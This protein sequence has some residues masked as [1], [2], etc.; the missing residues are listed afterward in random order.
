ML[1][2]EIHTQ[3]VSAARAIWNEVVIAA[4]AFPQVEPLSTDAEALEFFQ[5]QTRTAVAVSEES[6][7]ILGLYILHPNNIGRCGHIANASYAVSTD[8]RGQGVGRALIE[9]S[10]AQL[11][12]CGF[13]GL[14]FNAV[15]ASNKTAIALYEKLGFSKVGTIPGGFKNAKGAFEDIHIFYHPAT[16]AKSS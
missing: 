13:T 9:D 10:I 12:P 2:R 1:I 11:A 16:P 15:V 4:D 14:Q 5:S 7:R 3:D 8:A 6:G